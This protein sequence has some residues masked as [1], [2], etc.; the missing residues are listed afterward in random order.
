MEKSAN[1]RM[2]M[3]E[4]EGQNFRTRRF[5]SYAM[6][7]LHPQHEGIIDELRLE[8]DGRGNV[9]TDEDYHD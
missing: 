4:V 3:K 6:G 2:T 5:D 7:F 8:L 1:G 9:A